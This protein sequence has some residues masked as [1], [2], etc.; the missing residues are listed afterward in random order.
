M[1]RWTIRL[2]PVWRPFL[3]IIGARPSTCWVELGDVLRVQFGLF[4]AEVPLTDLHRGRK[5]KWPLRYGI[6][7]RLAPKKTVG[8]V[9][10][11]HGVVAVRLRG[12]RRFRVI[13]PIDRERVAFSLDDPDGFL[14]ALRKRLDAP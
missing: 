11:R 8:Y 4:S 5:I 3:L 9:G 7:V 1:S 2:D 13:V 6:G 14:A 12:P 10:S